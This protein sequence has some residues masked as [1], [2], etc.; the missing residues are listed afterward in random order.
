ME[1][2]GW[3]QKIENY[4]KKRSLHHSSSIAVIWH[5]WD[6]FFRSCFTVQIIDSEQKE[7]VKVSSWWRWRP[8]DHWMISL[9]WVDTVEGVVM[10]NPWT[11]QHIQCAASAAIHCNIALAFA[12]LYEQFSFFFFFLFSLIRVLR[13]EH[14]SSFLNAL[15]SAGTFRLRMVVGMQCAWF[16]KVFS[17]V[18]IINIKHLIISISCA[19][20]V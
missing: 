20:H 9:K 6:Y 15:L 5:A 14:L 2:W 1:Q 16:L 19:N 8:L 12:F 10:G 7:W 3:N 11:F 13:L 18:Y 17:L 4:K